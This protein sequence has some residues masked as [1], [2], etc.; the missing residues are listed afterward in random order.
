M[1]GLTFMALV[2]ACA[3]LVHPDTAR[4]L[5]SVE[6][7]FNPHAIG[8]VGDVLYRQPR[9]AS[10]ALAT[11]QSLKRNGWNFSVG[12]AQINVRNLDR[13]E[14]SL[15]MAF[16]ACQNLKAMQAVLVECAQRAGTGTTPQ[17]DPR[18]AATLQHDR[19]RAATVQ[20]D[21]RRTLSCYY[22]GSFTTGLR[23]GYVSRVVR[24]AAWSAPTSPRSAP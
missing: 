23:H 15:P 5:V 18:R 10:E 17:H 22:S 8:V 7:G 12:L 21:L 11:A 13:L 19:R 4:A 9:N 2:V 1:D 16:N 3:P 14:L 24:A 20:R 6:S